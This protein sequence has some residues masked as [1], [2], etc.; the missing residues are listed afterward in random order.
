M[1]SMMSDRY[2]AEH[3]IS[4]ATERSERPVMRAWSILIGSAMPR[5]LAQKKSADREQQYDGHPEREHGE[6]GPSLPRDMPA[7]RTTLRPEVALVRQP[8]AVRC[9]TD[10][11]GTTVAKIRR[12]NACPAPVYGHD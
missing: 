10:E 12:R 8:W 9:R 6:H 1:P 4:R 7:V 11:P 5:T 3:G 2:A